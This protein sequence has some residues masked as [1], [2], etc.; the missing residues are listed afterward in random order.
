MKLRV[1]GRTIPEAPDVTANSM[2]LADCWAGRMPAE[3]LERTWRDQLV[4]E[5]VAA[6][7]TDLQIAVHTRM[8]TY[9]TVR[10]RERLGLATN[11]ETTPRKDATWQPNIAG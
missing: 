11:T 4:F 5:L 10:I 7:W 9:T 6:G 1:H 3:A 8:S 2:V